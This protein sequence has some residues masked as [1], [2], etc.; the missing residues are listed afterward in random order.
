MFFGVLLLSLAISA[1]A[2]LEYVKT[3]ERVASSLVEGSGF[4]V[5][6][7]A[8]DIMALASSYNGDPD[9]IRFLVAEAMVN[10]K[11]LATLS[12]ALYDLEGGEHYKKWYLVYG[13]LSVYFADFT[14]KEHT[15]IVNRLSEDSEALQK[16]AAILERTGS[17]VNPFEIQQEELDNLEDLARALVT[18][19]ND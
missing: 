11:A 14:G 7:L 12:K 17:R 8:D 6:L 19:G 4:H 15:Y 13:S 10:S 1:F 16:I 2:N 18:S 9:K 3:E 5:S